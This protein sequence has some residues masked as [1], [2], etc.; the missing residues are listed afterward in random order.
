MNFVMFLSLATLLLIALAIKFSNFKSRCTTCRFS[1][2]LKLL[3]SNYTAI[4]FA[5]LLPSVSFA[6]AAIGTASPPQR[7]DMTQHWVGY[8]VLACIR[9]RLSSGN[10]RRSD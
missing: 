3:C 5:L 9:C 10:G 1:S 4:L 2:L 6:E 7:I 8:S